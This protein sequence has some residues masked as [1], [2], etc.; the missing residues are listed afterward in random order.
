MKG[1]VAAALLL[2]LPAP[3]GGY[4]EEI[5]A[6]RKGREERLKADGG[7]L[8]VEGLY[9]LKPG[10]SSFGSDKASTPP[11]MWNSLRTSSGCGCGLRFTWS[12]RRPA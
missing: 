4:V 10:S 9:W 1:L 3:S 12:R 2:A 7:W 8:S 11:Q 6:W 5:E